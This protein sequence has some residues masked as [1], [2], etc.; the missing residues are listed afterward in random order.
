VCVCVCVCDSNM[1]IARHNTAQAVINSLRWYDP[2]HYTHSHTVRATPCYIIL[3]HTYFTTLHY[4]HNTKQPA[5]A[6]LIALQTYAHDTLY[7]T[8][9]Y[10]TR[11]LLGQTEHS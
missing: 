4:T 11:T 9:H 3:R 6:R 5:S 10:T 7:D 2:V 8:T 1:Y